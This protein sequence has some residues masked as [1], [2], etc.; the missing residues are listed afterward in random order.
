MKC[1]KCDIELVDDNR[2]PSRKK[3]KQRICKNCD[4]K[5]TMNRRKNHQEEYKETL[6]KTSMNRRNKTRIKIFSLLGNRCANPYNLNHGDFLLDWRCLQ[7]DHV[8]GDGHSQ[9][10]KGHEMYMKKILK[11]IEAGSKDYQLLCANCNWIKRYENN[12]H[13]N[14]KKWVI[15]NSTA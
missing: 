3:H 14:V 7:I 10:K 6:K 13:G 9:G 8:N 1:I 15:E 12:E 5:I 4:N 2:Y 11:A